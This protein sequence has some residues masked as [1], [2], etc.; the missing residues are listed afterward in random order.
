[1]TP[2][3]K[4][5]SSLSL[6]MAMTLPALHDAQ[7]APFITVDYPDGKTKKVDCAEF[8]VEDGQLHLTQETM[9]ALDINNQ[10]LNGAV[11]KADLSPDKAKRRLQLNNNLMVYM[12]H[13]A[14][15]HKDTVVQA[16][17]LEASIK[18]AALKKEGIY[19]PEKEQKIKDD[20]AAR[21]ENM[22]GPEWRE[23]KA[24]SLIDANK[25]A[26]AALG[27]DKGPR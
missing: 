25:K 10:I 14:S 9:I 7:A 19:T 4:Y 12:L 16:S 24:S 26:K 3:S 5:F 20:I 11:A 8:Y 21:Y 1:M 13:L 22:C 27:L 18:V 6:A 2:L 23:M 17:L 15:Q